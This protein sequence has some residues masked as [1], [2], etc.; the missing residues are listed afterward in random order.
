MLSPHLLTQMGKLPIR[1]GAARFAVG[2]PDGL[3]SNSWRVWAEKTS[4][5]YIACRDSFKE[6]KVSLHASGRWRMGF[7][8]EAIAKRPDLIAANADRAWEVWDKPPQSLPKTTTAFHLY[9]PTSEL[10]LMPKDRVGKEWKDVIFIEAAP[11]GKVT[12][13][14][15]FI[16]SGDF[17]VRH[18]S[19]PSFMLAS[20]AIG[21][22]RY[23]K[24]VAHGDLEGN[25]PDIIAGGV[26]AARASANEKKID[27]PPAAFAYLF[28]RRD[29]GARFLVGARM[30]R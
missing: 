17:D 30:N 15:L 5:V 23:A 29:N 25:I 11:P 22:N 20:F 19:E 21:D 26:E 4:D 18:E 27:V 7:T 6:T 10:A 8:T 28:G 9:F 14:T 3:S 1:K 2:D 13:I 24:L 12:I 16:T